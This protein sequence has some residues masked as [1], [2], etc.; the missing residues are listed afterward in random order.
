MPLPDLLIGQ[1]SELTLQDV[2]V[3]IKECLQ[4]VAFLARARQLIGC[5]RRN[6]AG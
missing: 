5:E 3:Q 4:H 6:G 1:A 2:P